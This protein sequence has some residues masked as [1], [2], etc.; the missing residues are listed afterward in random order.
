MLAQGDARSLLEE[1]L[2]K[3]YLDYSSSKE[4]ENDISEYLEE[5]NLNGLSS[6]EG[7]SQILQKPSVADL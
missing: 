7:N 1:L 2:L 4:I 3:G 5:A 6:E